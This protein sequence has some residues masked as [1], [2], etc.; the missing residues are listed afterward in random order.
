VLHTVQPATFINGA[1]VPKHFTEA[2]SNIKEVVAFVNI[3]SVPLKN[4]EAVLLIV[5]KLTFV[6][7]AIQRLVLFP[8]AL[9][10]LDSVDVVAYEACTVL[11]FVHAFSI[12]LALDVL[13]CKLIAVRKNVSSLAML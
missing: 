7:I 2:I 3:S 9:A 10:F 5:L 4:T 11:P 8:L 1:I 12:W 6:L 13:A